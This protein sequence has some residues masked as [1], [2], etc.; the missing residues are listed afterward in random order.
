MAMAL[1]FLNKRARRWAVPAVLLL[2]LTGGFNAK[3]VPMLEL[4]P[5]TG[6]VRST[7]ATYEPPAE[8]GGGIIDDSTVK[9]TDREIYWEKRMYRPQFVAESH[10]IQRQTLI[11][12]S[13]WKIQRDDGPDIDEQTVTGTCQR[14]DKLP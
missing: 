9:I 11:Y 8:L 2:T 10:T 4:D 7:I 12:Q 13:E 5:G 3:A 6:E 14:I 1:G